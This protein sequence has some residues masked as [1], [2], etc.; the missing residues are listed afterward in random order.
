MYT[1][2]PYV[3]EVHSSTTELHEKSHVHK[4]TMDMCRTTARICNWRITAFY[5]VKMAMKYNDCSMLPLI[6]RMLFSDFEFW[7]LFSFCS[8]GAWV[9]KKNSKTVVNITLHTNVICK[10][11]AEIPWVMKQCR[12]IYLLWFGLH[13]LKRCILIINLKIIQFTFKQITCMY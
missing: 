1:C 4:L 3:P 8:V 9:W 12:S 6:S 2:F 7:W 11:V 5:F 13:C 10:Y